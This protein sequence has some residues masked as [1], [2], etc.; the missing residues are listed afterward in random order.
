M[1][2]YRCAECGHQRI[3]HSV[4][5]GGSCRGSLSCECR[6]SRAGIPDEPRP[7]AAPED[8]PES[9]CA[10]CRSP[11]G[12][13]RCDSWWARDDSRHGSCGGCGE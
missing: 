5:R 1:P 7:V 6:E 4:L 2:G 3:V 9:E 8:P 12:V 13:C 10:A 11:F